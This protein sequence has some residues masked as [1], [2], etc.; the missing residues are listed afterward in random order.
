[1]C[2][3]SHQWTVRKNSPFEKNAIPIRTFVSMVYFW[4]IGSNMSECVKY[5]QINNTMGEEIMGTV[6]D[7][8]HRAL[9]RD[10]IFLGGEN[11]ILISKVIKVYYYEEVRF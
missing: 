3:N 9:L 8:C 7:V 6:N 4:C 2:E 11:V 1:M 10:P 5:F